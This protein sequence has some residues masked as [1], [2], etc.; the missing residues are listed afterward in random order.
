MALQPAKPPNRIPALP[1]GKMVNPDGN[2]S[3]E[4]LIFRQTLM[5]S[6][7]SNIGSEGLVAPSQTT[8]D[9]DTI[10]A[11]TAQAQGAVPDVEYTCQPG[12]FFYDTTTNKVMVTI[13]VGTV[14]TL[15][16]VSLI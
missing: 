9:I 15:K 7:I 10:V 6:L 4:E 12:T 3:T 11:A 16:E 1:I 13:L 8:D 14:P 2:P 5:S